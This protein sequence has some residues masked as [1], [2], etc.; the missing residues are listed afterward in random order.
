MRPEDKGE[1][2]EKL[3]ESGKKVLFVGDG[4]NDAV[5][6]SR[7][8]VGIAM[9]GGADISKEAGDAVLAGGNLEPLIALFKLSELVRKKALENLLWAFAYNLTLV[10][11][12]AGILWKPLGVMLRP[13][14]AA[15]AMMASDITVVVNA[16]SMLRWQNK[17]G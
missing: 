6:L 1:L 10:P 4:I 5:A 13:E 15:G 17:R 7:A 8:F 9:G 12:A 16:V 11:I 3:Q 2:V 14:L